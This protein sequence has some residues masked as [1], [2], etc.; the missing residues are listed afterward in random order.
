MSPF[1]KLEKERKKERKSSFYG[2]SNYLDNNRLP[3]NRHQSKENSNDPNL[4]VK[5]AVKDYIRDYIG[6][7]FGNILGNNPLT[8]TELPTR[9]VMICLNL[10][11]SPITISGTLSETKTASFISN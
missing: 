4:Q 10:P 6:F 5:D 1:S 11:G 9:F 8:F 2:V 7:E 3:K